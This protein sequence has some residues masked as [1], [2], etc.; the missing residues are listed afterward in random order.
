MQENFNGKP[1][2]VSGSFARLDGKDCFVE[3]DMS[4]YLKSNGKMI[5]RFCKYNPSNNNRME[6][7]IPIY[8]EAQEFLGMYDR[9]K[10]SNFE[11]VAKQYA[12]SDPNKTLI[13]SYS[14]YG[15]AKAAA[16]KARGD[17]PFD[18]A[19]EDAVAKIL[20]IGPSTK[21]TYVLK[22]TICKGIE[23]GNG[24][25]KPNRQKDSSKTIMIAGSYETILG[26]F[27]MGAVRINALEMIRTQRQLRDL[28]EVEN[29][30]NNNK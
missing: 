17:I 27:H 25:V 20:E 18:I 6:Y 14:G 28:E 16:L 4:F 7:T 11:A 24:A 29:R 26:F 15:K 23:Q 5:M 13:A 12:N 19:P 8:L 30:R 22:G 21:Y 10:S 1:R 2:F 3:L 9:L